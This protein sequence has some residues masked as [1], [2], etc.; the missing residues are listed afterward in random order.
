MQRQA[1]L[2]GP[3]RPPGTAAKPRRQRCRQM[4]Q[5]IVQAGCGSADV[6]L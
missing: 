1:R 2:A 5:A 6:L 4:L 3:R